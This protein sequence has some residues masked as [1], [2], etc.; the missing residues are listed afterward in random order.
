LLPFHIF[1]PFFTTKGEGKGTG[2][3]LST[4]Y[5]IVRQSGGDVHVY[6]EPGRGTTFRVYLPGTKAEP[7]ADRAARAGVTRGEGEL[8]L[9]VEDEPAGRP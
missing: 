7:A 2:L 9:V 8:V 3:G 6:S 5:G 4:V 1:E